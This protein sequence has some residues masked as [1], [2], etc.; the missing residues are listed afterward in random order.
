MMQQLEI[1]YFFPL[2][3]QIPLELD[4]T[5]TEKY[6][7]DKRAEQLQNSTVISGS[8]LISNGGTGSTWT[9][10]ST[11]LGSPSFTINVDAMPITIKSKTKPNFFRRYIYKILGM[12]WKVE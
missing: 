12:K 8:Y 3:E 2:T 6:I 7:L 11:N 9:T 5:L 1:E 4:F 10:M